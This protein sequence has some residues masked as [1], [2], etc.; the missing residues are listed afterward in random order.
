MKFS[1]TAKNAVLL[2]AYIAVSTAL[3]LWLTQ[4]DGT[5]QGVYFLGTYTWILPLSALILVC[6]SFLLALRFIGKYFVAM[7]YVELVTRAVMQ[8]IT[9][10]NLQGV[11]NLMYVVTAV[12]IISDIA[13]F[14]L[15]CLWLFSPMR[16]KENA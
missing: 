8:S 6:G 13:V 1:S 3:S 9:L 11:E 4:Y 10:L 14:V 2:I 16:K 5:H 12:N 7:C 15:F